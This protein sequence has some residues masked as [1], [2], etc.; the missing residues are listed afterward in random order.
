LLADA[1]ALA[2]LDLD[3]LDR[4]RPDLAE[5]YRAAADHLRAATAHAAQAIG[6]PS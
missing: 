3:A 6:R 2:R 5:R 1:L 4:A